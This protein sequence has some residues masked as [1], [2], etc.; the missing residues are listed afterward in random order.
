MNAAL[1]ER[2]TQF[3]RRCQ[4][5]LFPLVETDIDA[6]LTPKLEQL[7]RIWEMV[8]IERFVPSA[9][10]FVGRP[11]LERRALA[12]AFV[13]KAVLGLTETSALVE[14]LNADRTLRR[15]CG[16]DLHRRK[17]LNASLVFAG[18][19]RVYPAGLAGPG[20]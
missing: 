18:V 13:A 3:H 11:P 16:F 12:R 5:A 9:R 17:P 7:L 8:E 10:G 14:R 6:P 20:A 4:E 2:L 15:L 1:R 19:C